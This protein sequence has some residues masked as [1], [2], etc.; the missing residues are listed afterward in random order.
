MIDEIINK[1]GK[2]HPVALLS[3]FR[4]YGSRQEN[5]TQFTYINQLFQIHCLPDT[6][7]IVFKK[8]I[9]QWTDKKFYRINNL[10]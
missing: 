9:I 4:A 3:M 1:Q 8:M 6:K 7:P 2:A 10:K 5:S